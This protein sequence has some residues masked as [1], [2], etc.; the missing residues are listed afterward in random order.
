MSRL[1][2][3]EVWSDVACPWCYVGKRHLER[4]LAEFDGP[5]EV[6]WHAF[7]LAPDAPVEPPDERSY[8]ERLSAK[9]GVP[10]SGAEAM[11]QRIVEA[12]AKV[13][14]D[15]RFDRVRP[16]NTFDAHRLLALASP[17]EQQHA[18]K[19]RLLRAYFT[20]GEHL[21]RVDVLLR[22][23]EEA[24]LEAETA[25]TVLATERFADAVRADRATAHDLGV[26]GVPFFVVGSRFGLAGA[27]PPEVIR[28]VLEQASRPGPP[29]SQRAAPAQD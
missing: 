12:G 29:A 25:R 8:A 14:L 3:I 18:L 17:G 11:I 4:A 26:T 19:E 7:Q 1:V 10:V 16:T 9:Y 15:F 5:T 20:E 21:G 6:S 2:T 28:D 24:G 27:Q 22:L 23:A 13:D